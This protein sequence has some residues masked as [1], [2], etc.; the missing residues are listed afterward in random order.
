MTGV[1]FELFEGRRR[2]GILGDGSMFV[3]GRVLGEDLYVPVEIGNE[4][5]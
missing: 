2:S 4:G 3:D 5:R 1:A